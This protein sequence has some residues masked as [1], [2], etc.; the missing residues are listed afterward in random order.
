MK[1]RRV[2]FFVVI[3]LLLI[4]SVNAAAPSITSIVISSTQSTTNNTNQNITTTVTSSDD[5][6]DSVKL[7]Y[8]WFVNRT[9]IA[10]LNMPFEKINGTNSN[11]AWDY[12]GY[13]NNGSVSGALWNSTG[14]F[15]GKGA[16]QFDGVDDSV[17]VPDSTNFNITN[18][19]SIQALI[20]SNG[21]GNDWG[22]IV[23][24]GNS[25]TLGQGKFSY[26][27]RL[28]EKGAPSFSVNLSGGTGWK[29]ATGSTLQ[30][31]SWYHLV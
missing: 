17:D 7:I 20:K 11:K 27:L 9:S 22:T 4:I 12:S 5:D 8:N 6:G 21:L 15:D 23:M 10:V 14:G 26:N 31:K 16:Y 30:N 18:N 13:G 24:K 28:N 3:F 25:H 2:I 19:I 1:I 29:Y